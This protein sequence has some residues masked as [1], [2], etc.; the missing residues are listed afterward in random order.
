MKNHGKKV[1]K[2]QVS[3]DLGEYDLDVRLDVAKEKFTILVPRAPG[4]P[5]GDDYVVVSEATL[6]DTKEAVKRMVRDRDVVGFR[7]VIEYS[8]PG[9]SRWSDDG[10]SINF[11]FRVARVSLSLDR[12]KKPLLEKEIVVDPDGAIRER[13]ST[14]SGEPYPPQKYSD[15]YS[16]SMPY[17]TERWR[18]CEAIK[19]AVAELRR[20]LVDLLGD[21][22]AAGNKLDAIPALPWLLGAID[23]D[24]QPEHGPDC[25]C[26]AGPGE[27]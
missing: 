16:H 2:Y 9:E 26:S 24:P 12:W 22:D 4:E 19:A 13:E 3:S 20:R 10:D 27:D 23:R 25:S 8:G 14:F 6:G 17:T 5:L 18:K 11:G 15:N 1:G 7:D 21:A